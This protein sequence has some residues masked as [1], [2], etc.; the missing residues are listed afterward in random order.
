[1][2]EKCN[3]L[4]VTQILAFILHRW[5]E[6]WPWYRKNGG[7]PKPCNSTDPRTGRTPHYNEE[8]ICDGI[9]HC[10][11]AE[12]EDFENCKK[13]I[14]FPESAT[15]ECESKFM[16]NVTIL[17]SPCNSVKECKDDIDEKD[18]E[19]PPL[20]LGL[21][22]GS[23]FLVSKLSSVIALKY[24]RVKQED[25]GDVDIENS[26]DEDVEALVVNSKNSVQRKKACWN[27][28][29]RKFAQ[30]DGDKAKAMN[31]LKV[32]NIYS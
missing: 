15:L 19:V 23:C 4:R 3:I 14:V 12:D 2:L 5:P 11:A 31:D 16:E 21:V 29:E 26:D 24:S 27:L 13:R 10:P 8:D 1:M 7:F 30:H 18:C 6:I 9:I 28:W 17:A 22:L 25:V 32:S 20:I